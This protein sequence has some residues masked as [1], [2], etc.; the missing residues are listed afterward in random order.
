MNKSMVEQYFREIRKCQSLLRGDKWQDDVE[1]HDRLRSE[2][3]RHKK[4]DLKTR[5]LKWNMA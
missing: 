4:E 2:W 5:L 1:D 3:T